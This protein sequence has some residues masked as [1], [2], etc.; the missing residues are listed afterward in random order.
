[1][2]ATFSHKQ[3]AV[4]CFNAVW[5]FLDLP[6]RTK[7]EEE[8]MLHLAHVSF[9]HWTQVEEHTTKNLSIGYWQL[10][11]VYAI[12]ELGERS[13][14]YANR[15]LEVSKD[16]NIEP[17]YIGYA[18]EALSRANTLLGRYDLSKIHSEHAIEYAQKVK[19]ESSKN[20]LLNDIQIIKSYWEKN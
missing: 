13:H 14:Y 2:T 19:D 7:E 5:D 1:M 11:R 3:M 17:F 12:T 8:K 18:Y 10:S 4:N 16:N 15:C 9:W 6:E 20:M